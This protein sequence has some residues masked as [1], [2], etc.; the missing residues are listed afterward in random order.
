MSKIHVFSVSAFKIMFSSSLNG[1]MAFTG[2]SGPCPV[3]AT[4]K[5]PD[6]EMVGILSDQKYHL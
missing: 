2:T 3:G 4:Q 6:L 1:K 5:S